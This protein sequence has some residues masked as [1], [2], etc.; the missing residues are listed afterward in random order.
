MNPYKDL[1]DSSRSVTHTYED[2]ATKLLQDQYFLTALELHTELVENGKELPQLREF[3]SNPGNFEQHASRTTDFSSMHRTPSLATLDSLDTARYS[4]DGGGDRTG[5]G[6]DVAVLEFELRKARETINSLRANLTQF[7]AGLVSTFLGNVASIK[8]P[9][10]EIGTQSEICY[11]NFECQTE[12]DEITV[13]TSCQTSLEHET[14]WNHELLIQA[15][16]IELL[17][18]KII[19][20]EME[21][22]NFQKLYDAAIVSL[23]S[24][25]SPGSESKLLNL[26]IPETKL[27]AVQAH[28]LELSVEPQPLT[29]TATENYYGSN[30]ST[31]SATPEQ[32]E[33]IDNERTVGIIRK[34]GSNT[35]SF[36]PAIIGD[37]SVRG[38]PIGRG[39]VTTLDESLSI[40]DAAD[41]TRL[42]FDC[43][44][45]ANN[46]VMWI[47]SGLANNLKLSLMNWC[48][49]KY[50]ID[51]L[52][53][54]PVAN[55]CLIE[56]V[57]N[58]KPIDLQGLLMLVADTLPKL[59]PHTL[60]A[61]RCEA[62]ALLACTVHLLST[63][64]ANGAGRRTRLLQ[65]L[66]TLIKKPDSYESRVIHEATCLIV[67]WGGSGE[68]LSCIAELLESRSSE[69]RLLASQI[70]L[71]IAPYVSIELC[72][73][74]LLSVMM[75]MCESTEV[76]I[77]V[78]G[79]KAA[80][81]ICPV[82][83]HKYGQLENLL[84]NFL[85]DPSE[86][87][88]KDAI[89]MYLPLLARTALAAGKFS[90]DLCSR[91]MVNLTKM[92][93]EK[94]WEK[95]LLYLEIMKV[96]VFAKLAYVVN[97]QIV[98]D[99]TQTNC[100]NESTYQEISL[101]VDQ[102]CF[103]D[104]QCY[105][106]DD[107]DG[108]MLLV[109]F[110]KLL[111]NKPDVRWLELSWFVNL[112]VVYS[113]IRDLPLRV[114]SVPLKWIAKYNSDSLNLYLQ[115]LRELAASSSEG[116]SGV[117]VRLYVANLITEL[118][119]SCVSKK[120][121]QTQLLQAV[122]T[123]MH[124]E[125]GSVR[126]SAITAWGSLTRSC[127]TL[128][129]DCEPHCWAALEDLLTGS[130]TGVT[131]REAA[132]AAEALSLLVLPNVDNVHA[133]VSEK[134]V[135][136]LCE[137]CHVAPLTGESVSALAPGLR[138]VAHHAR[139]HPALLPALRKIEESLQSP[140]LVQY[141][142]SIE[143]L[144]HNVTS[145]SS[146]SY[147]ESREM[148]PRPPTSNLLAAQEA[149]GRRMTQMFQNSKNNMNIPNIFKKKT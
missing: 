73:S 127:I 140:A 91:I 119:N 39:S 9:S 60:V 109:A 124:D 47:E 65:Q 106:T 128:G 46:K 31:H 123:L 84:F 141:K 44:M 134:A 36:D 52:K 136:L 37:N 62:V 34:E 75:L 117:S 103:S 122:L 138:L 83:E 95:V 90:F 58:D 76:E 66:L 149:V 80:C 67:K 51:E 32:F 102:N 115:L 98:K 8:I 129:L 63:S 145:P 101:D 11:A 1:A 5:S 26:D 131:S 40:N 21:K 100:D 27:Q 105:I 82:A 81:L 2:I 17:K 6:G 118:L 35:S 50:N 139:S 89:N 143:A 42:Q 23:N 59:L 114:L 69:R 130:A 99:V 147:V 94:D 71:S 22:L 28:S 38:S 55:E 97:V 61:R 77:R 132:R 15:E 146:G 3:F 113:S 133:S 30:N 64:G 104:V 74:L 18:E 144:I 120:C 121:L 45:D 12:L 92:S 57:T 33:L 137:L 125:D 88:V 108:K 54:N 53:T 56:L 4:E 93:N 142:Q 116:A 48:C 126:E 19:A 68:V 70:C 14:D 96:L 20:L 79:L 85:K 86:G 72:T 110:N 111:N 148:H 49:G 135:N 87:I 78:L 16:E 13:C 7:A 41:W 29:S 112:W 25:T 10:C 24:L 43:P 107:V